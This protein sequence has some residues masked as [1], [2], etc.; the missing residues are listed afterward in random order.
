MDKGNLS[1]IFLLRI[2]IFHNYANVYQRVNLNFPMIF[3]FSYGFSSGLGNIFLENL[4]SS[5]AFRKPRDLAW[6]H[7]M[8]S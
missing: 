5:F 6:P 2:V 1:L 7:A 3:Q 8:H 4:P